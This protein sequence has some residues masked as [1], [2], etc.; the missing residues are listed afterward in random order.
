MTVE[1]QLKRGN[2]TGPEST[3]CNISIHYLLFHHLSRWAVKG[4]PNDFLQLGF[5]SVKGPDHHQAGRDLKGLWLFM[6]HLHLKCEVRS[7]EMR[8]IVVGAYN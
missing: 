4:N 3:L 8:Q 6:I 2:I 7:T 1:I 5:D